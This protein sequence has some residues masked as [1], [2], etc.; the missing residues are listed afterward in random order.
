MKKLHYVNKLGQVQG[1]LTLN[2]LK[3]LFEDNLI[4]AATQVCESGSKNWMCYF[5]YIEQFELESTPSSIK[6]D[7][8]NKERKKLDNLDDSSATY[9]KRVNKFNLMGNRVNLIKLMVHKFLTKNIQREVPR[10]TIW[11]IFFNIIGAFLLLCAVILS[12]EKSFSIFQKSIFLVGGVQSF[13][14]AFLI[15]VIT[16]IRW[17][18]QEIAFNKD[19]K[20]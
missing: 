2:E 11:V 5:E 4:S 12:F 3:S 6:S 17:F 19:L 13:L 18:L 14:I 20:D 15:N 10:N 8:T 16:D 9:S 1:P 7:K